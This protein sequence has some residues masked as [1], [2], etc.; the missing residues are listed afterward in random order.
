[1][2]ID[3]RNGVA[4]GELV[5]YIPSLILSIFLAFRHGFGRSSGWYFLIIFCLARIIGPCMS[6]AAISSPS[7]SIFTGALI[8]QNVG[9][10]PLILATLGLLSRVLQSINRNTRTFIQPRS[11]KLIEVFTLVGLILGII[12]GINAS[13]SYTTT[14]R[15]VPGTESKVSNI[16]FIVSYVALLVITI[17]TSFSISNAEN[18]ERRILLAI[19]IALPFLFVRLLYSILSTFVAHST[20]FNSFTGSVTILLCVALLEELVIVVIYLGIG[21][22]LKVQPKDRAVQGELQ[23]VSQTSDSQKPLHQQRQ[24]QRHG[25][26]SGSGNLLLRIAKKT[27]IGRLVMAFVPEKEEDVE[28]QQHYVRR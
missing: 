26:K 16:L 10:S 27:I 24:T 4:I 18:G 22:T 3:Y 2:A 12:G 1:M 15:W 21:M 14:G 25:Q 11:L 23:Q 5:V 20:K 6:L 7:V 13:D 19:A 8:L 9:L 28:M 17:L